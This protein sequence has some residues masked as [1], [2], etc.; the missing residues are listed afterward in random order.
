MAWILFQATHFCVVIW[1]FKK[2]MIVRYYQ[3]FLLTLSVLHAHKVLIFC[4]FI[5]DVDIY[6]I[7]I[8]MKQ[9]QLTK[10]FR[11]LEAKGSYL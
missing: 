3:I 5:M 9:M 6:I 4:I 7:D 8:Q 1:I 2:S 10:P 11:R